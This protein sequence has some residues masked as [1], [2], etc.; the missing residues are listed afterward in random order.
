MPKNHSRGY[1]PHI[2]VKKVQFITF[3]LHDSLP[4][5]LL[6]WCKLYAGLTNRQDCQAEIVR[7]KQKMMLRLIDKYE[8][9]GYGQCFLKDE[10]VAAMIRD[11]LMLHDGNKY[12][13]LAWCIMP[14]HVHV[15][16]S[17]NGE[18]S[19]SQ[20]LHSWRSYTAHAA[21]GILG[22]TGQ[23]WMSEYFDRYIRDQ[24]HYCRVVNYIANNPVK[25][26]LVKSPED[27]P[28]CGS[29]EVRVW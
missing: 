13:L 8:D 12:D 26:G 16:I 1:L 14:N 7:Q 2:E 4:Q 10:R 6:S 17:V 22:R 20:I 11:T 5:E 27:W 18:Y 23:F 15:L 28:W 19:L 21:N 24:D 29:R 9:S 3:R 25:A